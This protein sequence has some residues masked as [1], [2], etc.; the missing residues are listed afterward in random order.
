MPADKLVLLCDKVRPQYSHLANLF[1]KRVAGYSKY[2]DLREMEEPIEARL[3]TGGMYTGV[4]K[5]QFDHEIAKW[6]LRKTRET[7]EEIIGDLR[8]V[9]IARLDWCIDL[10]GFSPADVALYARVKRTQSYAFFHSREGNTFYLRNSKSFT[11]LIYDRLARLRAKFDPEA[12]CYGKDYKLTRIEMQLRG[13]GLPFRSFN[14]I[15]EYADF[16]F[17][18][19][20]RF[21]EVGRKKDDLTPVQELAAEGFLNRIDQYGLAGVSK[22]YSSS[23]FAYLLKKFLVP[24]K[25]LPFPKPDKL[26]QA[27]KR[28]WLENRIRFPRTRRCSA[29]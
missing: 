10:H 5:I 1:G 24:L 3:Y 16:H 9:T 6:G 25:E 20:L 12:D 4:N 2:I 15:E 22:L 17:L 19:R 7:A 21:W 8:N 27:S 28:D 14:D 23:E 29:S 11:L 13:R 18:R 26:M